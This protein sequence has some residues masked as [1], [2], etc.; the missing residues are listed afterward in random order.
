M[1]DGGDRRS[2]GTGPAGPAEEATAAGPT[3]ADVQ[4]LAVVDSTNR[5]VADAAQA[6]AAEGLVVVADEQTAG[7][8]RLGRR[9]TA[10]HGSALLC[11]MLFRPSL[12]PDHLHLLTLAVCLAARA[13]CAS[14]TG[15][16]AAVKW[17]NDLV[18]GDRKLAGVLGETV[19]GPSPA[20]VVGIGVNLSWPAAKA[21]AAA[22]GDD[23]LAEL[24]AVATSL[25]RESGA[26]VDR[27]ALL[28]ALLVQVDE[29]YRATRSPGGRAA[30]VSDYRAACSTIG[31]RVRVELAVATFEGTAVDVG[32]DGRLLVRH[33]EGVRQ[34]EAGDVVHLRTD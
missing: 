28:E 13:A 7:R 15:V 12:A 4:R 2:L 10:P 11:S 20:V 29:R 5:I 14:V 18:V 33:D 23:E 24:S 17:P 34:V 21:P 31:R 25:R 8:G 3:F 30:L 16:D 22:E 19:P 27:D 32:E 6:G 26:D 1:A 9:W